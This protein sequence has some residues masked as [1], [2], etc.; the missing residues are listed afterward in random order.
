META[1]IDAM[2]MNV[3]ALSFILDIDEVICDSLFSNESK[4]LLEKCEPLHLFEAVEQER[5]RLVYERH[6]LNRNYHCCSFKFLHEV[7][8]TTLIFTL[9]AELLFQLIYFQSY[10]RYEPDGSWIPVDVYEPRDDSLSFSSFLLG[11][12]PG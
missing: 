5:D 3:V 2:I 6:Q 8:P 11:P 4:S 1:T 10:C 7:F 9:L 12:L